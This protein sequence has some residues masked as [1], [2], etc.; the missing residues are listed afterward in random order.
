MVL[1]SGRPFSPR[2]ITPLVLFSAGETLRLHRKEKRTVN[3]IVAIEEITDRIYEIRG[4]KVMLDR[5]LADLYEVETKYL[6]R[7]VKR[8]I[9]RFPE[10]FMFELTRTE[11]DDWRCQ[12]GTSNSE[13]MGL[14][15]PPMAFTEQGVASPGR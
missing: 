4:R 5:D 15:H 7:A 3:D 10:D 8:N 1:C 11:M 2:K 9:E 12:F 14:R 13:K 6:K